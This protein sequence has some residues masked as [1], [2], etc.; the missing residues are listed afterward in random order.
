MAR[1]G[2]D[3]IN[4]GTQGGIADVT[5]LAARYL[6]RDYPEAVNFVFNIVHDAVYLRVPKDN[7]E[8]WADRLAE[9][10]IKA[11]K[12]YCKLPMMYYKDIPM[13]VEVEWIDISGKEF[14]KEYV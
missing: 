14:M 12:E 5:K 10:M 2:T 8:I 7:P 4:F 3:A 1:L 13:P 9:A 11:W 6:C